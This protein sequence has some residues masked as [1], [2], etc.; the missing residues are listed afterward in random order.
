MPAGSLGSKTKELEPSGFLHRSRTA[1]K[2][3]GALPPWRTEGLAIS[4]RLKPQLE[5]RRPICFSDFIFVELLVQICSGLLAQAHTASVALGELAPSYRV[6]APRNRRWAWDSGALC[7]FVL[8][9]PW[10]LKRI[11]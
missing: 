7:L 9:F 1:G 4:V 11:S 2:L 3:R 5:G 8:K 10:E 6:A